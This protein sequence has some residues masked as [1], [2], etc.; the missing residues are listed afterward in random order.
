MGNRRI[1]WL[2]TALRDNVRIAC[3]YRDWLGN[4]AFEH[5]NKGVFDAVRT[6]AQMP[7]IGREDKRFSKGKSSYSTFAS[8]FLCCLCHFSDKVL[9]NSSEDVRT[10]NLN[11]SAELFLL[12]YTDPSLRSG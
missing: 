5:Y 3:W 1:I 10:K 6:L 8:N 4:K 12:T 11:T 7:T 9:N 2:N